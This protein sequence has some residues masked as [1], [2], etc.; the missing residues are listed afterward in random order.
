[1]WVET[2]WL[3]DSPTPLKMVGA[4]FSSRSPVFV[5]SQHLLNQAD[6]KACLSYIIS[7]SLVLNVLV[8]SVSSSCQKGP[9][10]WETLLPL[11]IMNLS[12]A[13]PPEVVFVITLF[14]VT[15]RL[16]CLLPC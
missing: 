7:C 15:V 5:Q 11:R 12:P 16:P 13:E 14:R 4:P 2:V 9:M 1:M 10:L 3:F 8:S 6:S